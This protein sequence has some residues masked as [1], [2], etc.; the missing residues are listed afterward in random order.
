MGYY[1]L[2]LQIGK[3]MLRLHSWSMVE[4]KLRQSK[5]GIEIE[6]P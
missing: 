6:P 2:H 4:G 5:L 3:L 1:Y